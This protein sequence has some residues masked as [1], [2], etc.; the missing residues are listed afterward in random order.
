M[1]KRQH[2]KGKKRPRGWHRGGKNGN[3]HRLASL[4]DRWPDLGVD[5]D[6][7]L[8]RPKPAHRVTGGK[9]KGDAL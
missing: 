4:L 5:P 3:G 8:S 6:P 9:W 2:A 1:G 7:E